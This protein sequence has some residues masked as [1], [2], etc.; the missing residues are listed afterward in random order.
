[1]IVKE[2]KDNL[3]LAKISQAF[4]A[5]KKCQAD[6][7]FPYEVNDLVLLSS[8]HWRKDYLSKDGKCV[9]KFVLHL[10][11]L[12]VSGVLTKRHRPLVYTCPISLLCFL[13]FI[14]PW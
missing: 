14:P 9:A 7:L 10:M 6:K 5:N 1:M 8:V 11:A 3:L 2:V 12:T 13:P 4:E